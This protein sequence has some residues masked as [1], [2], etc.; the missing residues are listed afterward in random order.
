MAKQMTPLPDGKSVRANPSPAELK[1]LAAKMPNARETRY[2]NL[3]VQ[4]AAGATAAM[5]WEV[6]ANATV[7]LGK[8]LGAPRR[9]P[10]HL[11]TET[12]LARAQQEL[13]EQLHSRPSD[14]VRLPGGGR[15]AAEKKTRR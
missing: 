1:Q 14:S 8:P 13:A 6:G 7:I 12:L 11:D 15:W 5:T 3:N 4:I 2:S 10:G 9:Q